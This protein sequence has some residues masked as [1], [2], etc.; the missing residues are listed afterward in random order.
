MEKIKNNRIYEV[1][2]NWLNDNG[3]TDY[4]ISDIPK[5]LWIHIR[6]HFI[7]LPIIL[8][9]GIISA[10]LLKDVI[11]ILLTL[12]ICLLILYHGLALIK[13]WYTN[14]IVVIPAVMYEEF[15]SERVFGL[16]H[17]R[18]YLLLVCQNQTYLKVFAPESIKPELGN[19]LE[20]YAYKDAF[21]Q[22]NGDT[23]LA[24]NY[25][26]L[27]ITKQRSDM[28]IADELFNSIDITDVDDDDDDI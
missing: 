6:R 23:V 25:L 28:E 2:F 13:D 17:S 7:V 12:G 14:K 26:V 21:R 15:E 19:E 4:H 9:A 11:A 27:K 10:I 3:A 24:S 20:I 5:P 22:L 16:F 1:L 18:R 8:V